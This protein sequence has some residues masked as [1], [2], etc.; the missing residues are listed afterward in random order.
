MGE[1]HQKEKQ[2]QRSYRLEHLYP[3]WIWHM[4]PFAVCAPSAIMAI[5][6]YH[7]HV[8]V[9]GTDKGK[10]EGTVLTDHHIVKSKL[11]QRDPHSCPKYPTVSQKPL[12]I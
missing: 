8:V 10:R 7:F 1:D 6:S 3:E 9:S 5:P 2:R 11:C 12:P 4:L